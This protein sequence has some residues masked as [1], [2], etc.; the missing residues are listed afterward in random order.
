M[1]K[2]T[3]ILFVG[4]GGQGTILASNILSQGLI[5]AG[6]DVKMSEVHGMAQRGGSVSTQIRFGKKVY[7]PLIPEKEADFILSFEKIE[8]GRWLNFLNPEGVLIINNYEIYPTTVLTGENKYPEDIL[9]KIKEKVKNCITVDAANE[10][11]K[12][13]NIKTQNMILLGVLIGQL[14]IKSIDWENIIRNSLPE[15]I[16]EINLKA[17]KTG[18]SIY[19]K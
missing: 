4:V 19:K 16:V 5:D 13:G 3:N 10:A 15:K 8:A 11:L 1:N 9:E 2:T 17:F 6:F 14:D 12:L 18:L 7:S